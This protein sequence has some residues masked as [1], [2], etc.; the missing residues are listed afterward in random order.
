MTSLVSQI[1]L[2]ILTERDRNMIKML[3]I[4]M[5][6]QL[7]QIIGPPIIFYDQPNL[8]LLKPIQILIYLLSLISFTI[9]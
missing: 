5:H 1:P 8:I 7:K 2:Y 6:H 4:I 9:K 3:Q